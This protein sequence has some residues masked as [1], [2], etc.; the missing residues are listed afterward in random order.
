MCSARSRDNEWFLGRLSSGWHT[1]PEN[2]V[3]IA[4]FQRR[5]LHR[6]SVVEIITE[7]NARV[8]LANVVHGLLQQWLLEPLI[9]GD[10]HT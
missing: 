5:T 8:D 7:R 4:R 2:Q 1:W 9:Q 3:L 6:S 10:I